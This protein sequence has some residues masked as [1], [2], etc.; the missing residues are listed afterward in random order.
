MI[1]VNCQPDQ[2]LGEPKTSDSSFRDVTRSMFRI[3]SADQ[4]NAPYIEILSSGYKES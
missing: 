1:I 2:T 4:I 3:L